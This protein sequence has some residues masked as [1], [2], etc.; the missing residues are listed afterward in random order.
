MPRK[1]LDFKKV[2]VSVTLQPDLFEKINVQAKK[3]ERSISF[4]INKILEKVII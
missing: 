2:A 4:V 3:E 1:K